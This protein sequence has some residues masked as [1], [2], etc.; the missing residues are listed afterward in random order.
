[1]ENKENLLFPFDVYTAH[2][3]DTH[4]KNLMMEEITTMKIFIICTAVT[5]F[6]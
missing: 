2:Y 3:C 5:A 6:K 4:L 1:M